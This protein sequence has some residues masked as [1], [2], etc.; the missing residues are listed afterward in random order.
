MVTNPKLFLSFG[1]I[2]GK[3]TDS[4]ISASKFSATS[5]SLA[6]STISASMGKVR[7]VEKADEEDCAI[8]SSVEDIAKLDV[9]E[10]NVDVIEKL[11]TRVDKTFLI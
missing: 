9:V 6:I 2:T 5:G 10:G 7:E 8:S 3:V 4:E 1:S 11:L